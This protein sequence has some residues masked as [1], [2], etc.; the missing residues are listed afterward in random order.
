M[1]QYDSENLSNKFLHKVQAVSKKLDHHHHTS[2]I[3][4][5][6]TGEQIIID[7]QRAW[8]ISLINTPQ[9]ERTDEWISENYQKIT[10]ASRVKGDKIISHEVMRK[11]IERYL[12]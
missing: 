9:H 6:S 4:Y 12:R 11:K 5:N 10:K 1:K 8:L 7:D 3:H 2:D